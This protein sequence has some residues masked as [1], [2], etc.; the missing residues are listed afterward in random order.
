M[1]DECR[2]AVVNVCNDGDVAKILTLLKSH[3]SCSQ[4]LD[5]HKDTRLRAKTAVI[6]ACAGMTDHAQRLTRRAAAQPTAS[7]VGREMGGTMKMDP[8][9]R[10]DDDA[11]DE[12]GSPRSRG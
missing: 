11:D 8:R 12:D 3:V 4:F 7:A 2:L 1:I 9:V 6:R 5:S 10:G